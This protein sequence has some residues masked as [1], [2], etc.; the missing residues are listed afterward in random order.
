MKILHL[1][2]VILL[3]LVVNAPV[4]AAGAQGDTARVALAGL[5][6]Q[7]LTNQPAESMPMQQAFNT[8]LGQENTETQKPREVSGRSAQRAASH[9]SAQ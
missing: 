2:L 3:G 1:G 6:F 8:L 9:P 4:R 5:I 7:F